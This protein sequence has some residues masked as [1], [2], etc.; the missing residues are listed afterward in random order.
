MKLSNYIKLQKIL[1]TAFFASIAGLAVSS[2]FSM[3]SGEVVT[4]NTNANVIKTTN[5]ATPTPI[6]TNNAP[7][8]VNN[9]S[10]ANS[11]TAKPNEESGYGWIVLGGVSFVTSLTSLLGFISTTVLAWR[12]EKRDVEVIRI[13]NEKKELE[14]EKLKWELEKLKQAEAEKEPKPKRRKPKPTE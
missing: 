13:E 10:A 7:V 2:F 8:N 5:N 11:T 9:N 12:K 3:N 6:A 1:L 14:L 4:A